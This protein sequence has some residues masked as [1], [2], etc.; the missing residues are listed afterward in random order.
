MR[1]GAASPKKSW[2][3]TAFNHRPT[4]NDFHADLQV[5]EINGSFLQFKG[6]TVLGKNTDH[7]KVM[8]ALVNKSDTV[9]IES[10]QTSD[11]TVVDF[12]PKNGGF[13]MS[14]YLGFIPLKE[15][16]EGDYQVGLFVENQDKNGF[17]WM[18]RTFHRDSNQRQQ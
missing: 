14:G 3:G 5:F 12:S 11:K 4:T 15:I 10:Y 16:P 6:W 17:K 2:K 8:L 7:Q 13:L 9:L 18:N 1:K